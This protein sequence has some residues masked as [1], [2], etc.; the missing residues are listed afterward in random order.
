MK[1]VLVGG[2]TGGPTS[3]LI[4]VAEKLLQLRPK[5][6]FVFIGTK[7]GPEKKMLGGMAMPF[8]AIPAGKWRRYF[9]FR[10]FFDLLVTFY[11]FIKSCFI[12][13]KIKPDLVFSAGAFSSVPVAYA[14]RLLGIKI[15]IH[16]QDYVPSFSNRLIYPIADKMTVSLEKSTRDFGFNSGLFKNKARKKISVTGNPV[17]GYITKG[18]RSQAQKIFAL[19]PNMPTLLIIGGATGASTLNSLIYEALPELVKYFQIIHITGEQQKKIPSRTNYHPYEFL[20]GEL[21]HAY[22]VADIVISRAGFSVISELSACK[23]VGI[24]IPISDS[25]QVQ[26]ARFLFANK[27]AIVALQESL[28]PELLV[29]LTRKLLFDHPT[30]NF[31]KNNLDLIMPHDAAEKIAEVII[32]LNKH[33][34]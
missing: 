2:G 5:T 14:A 32:S 15:L 21:A 11:G 16:Q 9:S 17:R 22:E 18:D 24:V 6:E 1:I 10:N 30:Q 8:F 23:K 3:P 33:D 31:L 4:A 20:T 12:L 19:N 26:N 25:H 7:A 27:A 34:K 29:R 28:N 13:S